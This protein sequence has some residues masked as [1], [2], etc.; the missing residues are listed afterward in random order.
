MEKLGGDIEIDSTPDVGTQITFSIKNMENDP[1]RS[2]FHYIGVESINTLFPEE[3]M[4]EMRNFLES[5]PNNIIEN[6]YEAIKFLLGRTA[7]SPKLIARNLK[8]NS[9]LVP[10]QEIN[11]PKP[12][13]LIVDDNGFNLFALKLLLK[14]FNVATQDVNNIYMEI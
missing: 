11:M 5:Y 7:S 4:N 8:K 1:N 9:S 10:A 13:I 14:Q 2:S 6:I 12:Y 3:E